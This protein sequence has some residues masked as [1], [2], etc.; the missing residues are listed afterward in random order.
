MSSY[1]WWGVNQ[2]LQGS[3]GFLARHPVETTLALTALANPG[4]RGFAWRVIDGAIWNTGRYMWQNL[5]T[6]GR[7]AAA[8]SPTA[9]TIGNIVRSTG[10]LAWTNPIITGVVISAASATVAIA[11]AKDEDPLTEQIQ[12]I[13][14][15][16]SLSGSGAGGGTTQPSI[17]TGGEWLIGGGSFF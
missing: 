13:S 15:S 10:R 17:G 7:A 5:V 6:V 11:L 8:E 16:H 3:V 12:M 1:V 14:T 2:I 9:R 4:T